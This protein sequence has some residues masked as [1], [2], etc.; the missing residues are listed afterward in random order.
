MDKEVNDRD[1]YDKEIIKKPEET[2]SRM[3]ST[4]DRFRQL[5]YNTKELVYNP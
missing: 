4:L 5:G 3:A 2:R 1:W